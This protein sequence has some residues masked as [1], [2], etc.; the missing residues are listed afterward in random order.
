MEIDFEKDLRDCCKNAA[1]FLRSKN[2]EYN[3]K[4]KEEN[5]KE[6]FPGEREFVSDVYMLLVKKNCSYRN[7]LF[8]DYLRP[9]KDEQIETKVPDLVFRD[10]RGHK[11]VVE[12]KVVVNRLKDGHKPWKI[13]LEG[14]N[15]TGGIKGDYQKLKDN[16]KSFESKLQV[17]AYLGPYLDDEDEKE[18]LRRFE[19]SIISELKAKPNDNINVIVC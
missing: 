11:S 13:D 2:L 9:D 18:F 10:D 17:V 16:Y 15:G 7:S 1:S 12:I 14:P 6:S 19:K 5:M 8:I 4:A 3:K